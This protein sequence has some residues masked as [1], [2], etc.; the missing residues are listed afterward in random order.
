RIENK[1]MTESQRL[2]A[3]YVTQGSEQAF[4]ELVGRYIDLVYSTVLR[5]VGGDTHR[6]QDVAQI[7]FADLARKARS[8][9]QDVMLGGWLHR[10]TCFVAAKV[11]RGER[12][13]QFRER[14]AVEMNALPDHAQTNMTELPP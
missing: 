1:T 10:D 9:S 7:V 6:A 8:L 4:R 5:L 14:R 2:L 3:D 13:R 12:R 11:M